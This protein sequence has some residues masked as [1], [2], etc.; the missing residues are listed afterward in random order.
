MQTIVILMPARSAPEV[1]LASSMGT[2]PS[3]CALLLA[4]HAQQHW[5]QGCRPGRFAGASRLL[6]CGV[7]SALIF[8]HYIGS[9]QTEGSNSVLTS[10][11]L[12]GTAQRSLA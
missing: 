11:A 3:A 8:V 5:Y 6:A 12:K 9:Q 7:L 2:Y 1:L 4:G 10:P